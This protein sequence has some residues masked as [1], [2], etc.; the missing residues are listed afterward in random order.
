M[1]NLADYKIGAK[2]VFTFTFRAAVASGVDPNTGTLTDPSTV[3]AIWQVPAGTE[4]VYTYGV[5]TGY[6][7]KTST[8]IYTFT[9]PTIAA[10]GRHVVRAKGTAGLIAAGEETVGVPPSKFTA[11]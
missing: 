7:S 10:A 1:S 4:T 6:V 9:P 8:G 2:P 5:D 11:P 3:I